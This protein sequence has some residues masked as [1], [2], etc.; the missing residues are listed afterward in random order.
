MYTVLIFTYAFLCSSEI[1]AYNQM[2]DKRG[3]KS[4]QTEFEM[5]NFKHESIE[6]VCI[7]KIVWN[8]GI[9]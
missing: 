7:Q 8:F 4:I 5:G 2:N 6:R 3:R 9:S 1:K